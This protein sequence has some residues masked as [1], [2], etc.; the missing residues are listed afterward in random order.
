MRFTK[1]I[2]T[3]IVQEFA[4]QNGGTFDAA[5]F[6]EHVKETGETHEAYSWFDWNNDTAAHEFR[7]NQAR[8][9]IRDLRISFTVQDVG[10]TGLISVRTV[11]APLA[12]SPID[13]R[14]NGGG[15]RLINPHSEDSKRLLSAEAASAL[16]SWR[17]RYEAAVAF[18]DADIAHVEDLIA[19]LEAKAEGRTIEEASSQVA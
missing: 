6:L 12:L 4:A 11:E 7:L 3:R 5:K 2:R 9:F 13:G 16:K 19:R 18:V 14:A 15:Y 1:A 10:R 8:S 17:S